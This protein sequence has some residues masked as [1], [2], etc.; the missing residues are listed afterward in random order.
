MFPSSNGSSHKMPL[1]QYYIKTITFEY[2]VLL[3]G[4]FFSLCAKN[5][6]EIHTH[7]HITRAIQERKKNP[8]DKLSLCNLDA[9]GITTSQ[10][11]K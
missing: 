3:L 11:I 5:K 2:F 6:C 9:A 8:S 10:S 1:K 4:G 7:T